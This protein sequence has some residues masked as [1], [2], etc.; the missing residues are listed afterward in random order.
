MKKNA[1]DVTPGQPVKLACGCEA[2][3]AAETEPKPKFWINRACNAHPGS[4]GDMRPLDPD[5]EVTEV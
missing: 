5:E 4:E 1:K 2:T 3:R